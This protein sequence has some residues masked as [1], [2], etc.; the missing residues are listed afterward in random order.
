MYSY[1]IIN[2]NWEY[3]KVCYLLLLKKVSSIESAQHFNDI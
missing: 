2:V 1:L 3:P